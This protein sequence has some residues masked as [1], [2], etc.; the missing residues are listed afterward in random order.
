MAVLTA[1]GS[2]TVD[3]SK[4]APHDG[5]CFSSGERAR[6]AARVCGKPPDRLADPGLYGLASGAP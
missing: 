3:V 5:A 1:N 6:E 2:A 4:Q